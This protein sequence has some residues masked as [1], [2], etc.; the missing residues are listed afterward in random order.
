MII[1]PLITSG[2][3][4]IVYNLYYLIQD[5]LVNKLTCSVEI[6]TNET[7]LYKA[8]N[9]FLSDPKFSKKMH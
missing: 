4:W 8:V 2:I 7:D 9:I 3:A 6:S 5:F 1:F